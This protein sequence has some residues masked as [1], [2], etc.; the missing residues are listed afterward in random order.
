MI[1]QSIGKALGMFG[2]AMLLLHL[3]ITAILF[4]GQD[5]PLG[6]LDLSGWVGLILPVI[7]SVGL[8]IYS[9]YLVEFH[10]TRVLN[11]DHVTKIDFVVRHRTHLHVR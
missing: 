3:L 9:I 1:R 11:H 8:M 4:N 10:Q 2:A 5:D 6:H 7:L